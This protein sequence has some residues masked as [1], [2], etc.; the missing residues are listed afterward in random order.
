MLQQKKKISKKYIMKNKYFKSPTHFILLLTIVFSLTGM[1]Y[2]QKTKEPCLSGIIHNKLMAND[3]EYALKMR[4]HETRLQKAILNNGAGNQTQTATFIVP[5]VVHIMHLGEA[6][7]T[8]T[9]IS[10][11]QILSAISSLND[12]YRKASGTPFF[13][14]GVDTGIEFCLVQKDPSGNATTGINRINASATGNYGTIGVDDATNE[15]QIKALSF[16]DNEKYYNIWVVSEISDN[17]GGAGT[18]GYAYFP[19]GGAFADDGTIILYNAFGYDPTG[20]LGYNLKS[21]TNTNSTMIH[22]MGHALDLYHTFNDDSNGS[23]CPPNTSGQCATEGDKVCDTPAHIRSASDCVPDNTVN[24]CV[25]GSTAMDF[26]HN[27]MDYSSDVCTNMFTAGQ[28]SRL[29]AA[30]NTD[31]SSLVSS[32][33]LAACGCSG[34]SVDIALTSGSIPTCSGQSLTFTATPTNGGSNPSYQWYANGTPINSETGLTYVSSTLTSESITC[35]MTSAGVPSTSNAIAV[36]TSSGIAPT[37]AIAVTSGSSQGCAGS[38]ITFTATATSGGTSPTYQWKVDGLNAGTNSSTY[39]SAALLNGQAVTCV[40]TSNLSCA[41]PTTANSSAITIVSGTAIA[42]SVSIALTA[43]TN[44]TCG[45]QTLTFNATQTNGGTIPVY[46]WKVNGVNV[47]VDSIGYSSAALTNG[48][49]IT[50]TMTSNAACASPTAITSAAITIT[51]TST[52]TINF[53]ANKNVC[54]GN[55]GSSSFTSTPAG[56]SYTWTNTNPA[57]GL[58]ASGTGNVPAFTAINSTSTAMVATI[59]VVPSINNTCV[60]TPSVYTITVNPT[61]VITESAGVLSSSSGSSYQWYCNGQ[62][63]IGAT[64]QS[65]TPTQNGDFVVIIGG[66]TCSSNIINVNDTGIEYVSNEE[67][68]NIYPNPNDGNFYISFNIVLKSNYR[69]TLYSATG[70]LV[71]KENLENFY[72]IYSKQLDIAEYGKG[73]YLLNISNSNTE[74]IKKIIVY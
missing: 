59:T 65:H 4:A 66:S 43:G 74:S 40:L 62:P 13:G 2:A 53:V 58:A 39:T 47:G 30:L 22:E 49:E 24:S 60:G 44:P 56:A 41:S 1:A 12:A 16:W 27:Y 32:A 50:C 69:L 5:L 9:N 8:G 48:Q 3:P 18:Q 37:I 29:T 42:P 35:I 54:G 11:A 67:L 38:S 14:N 71:Y 31:R 33:N 51:V 34:M 21:Y 28:S 6:V 25:S 70:S 23:S 57:I 73:I 68:I 15:S 52:P 36:T 45:G 20:S 61:P 72:G 19:P 10:T 55:I 26:Q 46:Q 63:V 64:S 17:D 7:G